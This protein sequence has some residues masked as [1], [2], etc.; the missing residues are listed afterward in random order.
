MKELIAQQLEV[1]D[2]PLAKAGDERFFG[3]VVAMGVFPREWGVEDG[4]TQ[5][6]DFAYN[7]KYERY[8]LPNDIDL[9]RALHKVLWLNLNGVAHTGDIYG[10][11]RIGLGKLG[12]VVEE[13]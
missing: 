9:K 12:Y 4:M 3:Y 5:Y 13:Q 1:K 2:W 6:A 11:V 10:K 7:Q 8:R